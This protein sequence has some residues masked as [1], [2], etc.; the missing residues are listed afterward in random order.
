MATG[1]LSSC[2]ITHKGDTHSGPY[3]E[4]NSSGRPT[5]TLRSLVPLLNYKRVSTYRRSIYA[6]N[7]W[8]RFR[9]PLELSNRI[10]I[11]TGGGFLRT[12]KRDGT[13]LPRFKLVFTDAL[14]YF[15]N[16]NDGRVTRCWL[17]RIRGGGWYIRDIFMELSRD[18]SKLIRLI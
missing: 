5:I 14:W 16:G 7:R 8:P 10:E 3:R 1:P 17:W 4:K 2:V 15:W 9:H 13:F 18:F 12:S 11:S 6:R